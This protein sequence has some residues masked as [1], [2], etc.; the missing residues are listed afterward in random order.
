MR[1]MISPDR[2]TNV[3]PRRCFLLLATALVLHRVSEFTLGAIAPCQVARS[4]RFESSIDRE[5]K[6]T[7][8][9]NYCETRKSVPHPYWVFRAQTAAAENSAEITSDTSVE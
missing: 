2:P 8:F 5:S 7:D 1:P 3:S 9:A 4:L 6:L